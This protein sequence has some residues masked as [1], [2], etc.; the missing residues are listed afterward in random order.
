MSKSFRDLVEALNAR[1]RKEKYPT[2]G[3]VGGKPYADGEK[4]FADAHGYPVKKGGEYDQEYPTK[5]TDDVLNARKAKEVD[6][7]QPGE[8]NPVQQGT[9]KLK[10]LSGFMG[11]KTKNMGRGSKTQGDLDIVTGPS[12]VK[13]FKEEVEEEIQEDVA[14]ALQ[15]IAKSGTSGVIKFADGDTTKV[16][17]NTAKKMLA[18]HSKLSPEN[19]KKFRETINHDAAGFLK[20][21][22]FSMMKGSE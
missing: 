19:A 12:T 13:A 1:K 4:D 7:D 20:V 22:N 11:K 10:D 3:K 18:I 6:M 17:S 2:D 21:M 15:K 8:K 5:N 9:S 14:Q 16:D